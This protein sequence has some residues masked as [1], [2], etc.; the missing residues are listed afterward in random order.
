MVHQGSGWLGDSDPVPERG[1]PRACGDYD[2]VSKDELA[3]YRP[4]T[5]QWFIGGPTGVHTIR[6]GGPTDVPIP[7]AYDALTT[8]THAIE[9]AVFRP[10]T[11]QFFIHGPSGTRTIQFAAGDIPVSGDFEGVGETEAG[12]YRP[13][14]GQWFVV[15]PKDKTPRLLA[16]YGGSTDIPTMSP[17]VYRALKSG[18]G[19][20][21]GFD[22]GPT[23][24]VDLA[25]SAH[26]LSQSRVPV[27]TTRVVSTGIAPRPA[28]A[29]GDK[30]ISQHHRKH[31]AFGE[32]LGIHEKRR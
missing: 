28:R 15:G 7:G 14:T 2:N 1:R 23:I 6:F 21:K 32:A 20:I 3:L 22:V 10:S 9:P 25:S 11:G 13:S 24:P 18:G 26:Q 30:A 4:S 12:V 8:G 27:A 5:G 29:I 19:P 17:Y 16:A 31:L